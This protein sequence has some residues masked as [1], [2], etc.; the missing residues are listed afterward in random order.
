MISTV[1]LTIVVSMIILS[2]ITN[3]VRP[4]YSFVPPIVPSSRL[5]NG[6]VHDFRPT[7]L[8][9]SNDNNDEKTSID[10]AKDGVSPRL[11]SESIAPWRTLRLFI[12][13]SLGSG[14][15]LGGFVTLTGVAASLSGSRP[16]IN[17]DMRT[18]VSSTWMSI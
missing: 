2:T 12:Y 7:F 13:G 4:V 11:L 10:D 17:L 14:A 5:V 3:N 8:A 15:L 6:R 9:E 16:D 1:I 18:E